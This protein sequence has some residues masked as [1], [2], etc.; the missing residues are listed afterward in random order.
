[1]NL[2]NNQSPIVASP[3]RVR[4]APSPTGSI[5]VG[6]ARSALYN[7]L[8]ARHNQ[9]KFIL[10]IEDTDRTRS[11][12]ESTEA[13]LEG[14]KWLGIDWDEGPYFQSQRFDIYRRYAERLLANGQAY[15]CYCPPA[16]LEAERQQ[17]EKA[18]QPWKYPRRCFKLS[19]EER[20]AFDR[21]GRPKA[22]RFLVPPKTV[23]F[24][25]IVHGRIEKHYVDIED[26]IIMRADGS[27]TYNLSCVIDD[28]EMGITDVIRAVEHIANTPKQILLYETLGF[29]V[30][31]FAHL[32]LILGSDRKKISKRH[33]AVS[34]IEYKNMGILPEA[35]CNFLALLGWSPG[36]DREIVS[37]AEMVGL[38]SLERVNTANAVFDLKKLEWMNGEY[39]KILPPVRL[40]KEVA[41]VWPEI[42]AFPEEYVLK[43]IALVRERTR[44]VGELKD[45]LLPFL[46]DDIAYDEDAVAKILTGA[47]KKIKLLRDRLAV[48][49]DFSV[50]A[51]EHALRSLAEAEGLKAADL[52]HPCRVAVTGKRVGPPLFDA[53]A[54]IGRERTVKRL[55]KFL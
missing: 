43:I 47:G 54:L 51:L 53:L 30:P 44:T 38:F 40:L 26:F 52:I 32:P 9:G 46:I 23:V 10:R 49:D 45:Q 29:A 24:E 2:T 31:R 13:I 41:A 15:W 16:E 5:H 21:E 27:P 35:M 3:I 42:T 12:Q 50:P 6:L 34:V 11:T 8:F 28:F 19:H 39:I 25:D 33:G 20:A 48:L 36:G 17:A 55:E 4:I 14:F 18:H 7:W 1:M 22:I 37:L